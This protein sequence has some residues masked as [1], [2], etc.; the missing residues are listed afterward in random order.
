M[1]RVA[2]KTG[3]SLSDYKKWIFNNEPKVEQLAEQR[4]KSSDF[5]F[6]PLISVIVPVWNTPVEILKQ[7]I[8][9]V[10]DQTYQYWELCLVDG[11]SPT[12]GLK[13]MLTE[14]AE[15][16]SRV[17]VLNSSRA[18]WVFLVI[19]MKRWGWHRANL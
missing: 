9:S 18:I 15:A 5:N 12:S 6:K 16:D 1:E 7:T 11:N 8:G 17:H 4:V 19:R 2:L 10:I 13:D 14:I 3:L